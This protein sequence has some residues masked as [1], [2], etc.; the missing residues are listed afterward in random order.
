[1]QPAAAE[2]LAGHTPLMKLVA[3][4]TWLIKFRR[5]LGLIAF[6][7]GIVHMI[8]YVALYAGFD[9]RTMLDDVAK[10]KFI[11]IGLAVRLLPLP[12][13]LTSA[14]RAIGKMSGEN[15]NRLHKLVYVAAIRGVIQS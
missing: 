1:L 9:L 14:H 10:R 11:I 3:K 15:W 4:L 13:A 5:L 8:S 7:C 2:T 6:F 12:F